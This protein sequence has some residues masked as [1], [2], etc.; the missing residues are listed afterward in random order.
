[1]S[2]YEKPVSQAANNSVHARF[3]PVERV[4]VGDIRQMYDIFHRYY[5]HT[6]M[7]TFVKDMSKK[8]G[9]ILIRRKDDNRI[10]GFST[11]LT[12]EIEIGR[13][14]GRGIFSGDTIVEKEYWGNKAL[15]KAFFKYVLTQK[16]SRPF[17]PLYW[18]LIS[19]GYKTYLTLANNFVD[20]YPHPENRCPQLEPIVRHYCDEMFP[21]CYDP[22]RGILDFG[23]N[24]QFL[25][26]DV[27][28]IT[29]E[30]RQ[31]VPKIRYFEECNPTWTRGTELPCVGHVNAANVVA[32]LK[33][34]FSMRLKSKKTAYVAGA[35]SGKA[36]SAS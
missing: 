23:E 16:L 25:K 14:K 15:Q 21:G 33:K 7:D 11:V 32:Y 34:W 36:G 5:G 20:Y 22:E 13:L 31:T 12:R 27:A 19:K 24:A 6:D 29:D 30:L 8:S 10:V 17:Q 4:S 9:V 3:T 18:L 35:A 2:A 1:M 26:N 28:A